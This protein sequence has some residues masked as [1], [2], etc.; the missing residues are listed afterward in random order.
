[1]VSG[2]HFCEGWRDV[3]SRTPRLRAT[4]SRC[5]GLPVRCERSEGRGEIREERGLGMELTDLYEHLRRGG[6]ATLTIRR[7]MRSQRVR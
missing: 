4:S 3:R 7:D 1:M 2:P 6:A 5:S